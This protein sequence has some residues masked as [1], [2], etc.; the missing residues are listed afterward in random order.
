MNQFL[1]IVFF[2]LLVIGFFTVYSNFGVPQLEPAPP[3]P[4]QSMELSGL[5]DAMLVVRGEELYMGKGACDLC[6]NPVTG[7][8][9]LL[10]QLASASAARIASSDYNGHATT[11][12]QYI[13]ES[14]IEPSAY[15]V[16]G[17]GTPGYPSPMP[18]VKAPGIDLSDPE[19]DAILAYLKD[20]NGMARSKLK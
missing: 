1:R 4:Q 2:S 3:P 19:I 14:L 7:R 5:S 18:S 20:L 16:P 8:A 17:F 15:I 12:A 10:D 6:H 9:P 13:H 11:A